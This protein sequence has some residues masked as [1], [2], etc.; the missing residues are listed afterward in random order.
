MGRYFNWTADQR[1]AR[2]CAT[3]HVS[4]LPPTLEAEGE[5]WSWQKEP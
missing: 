4:L 5:V 1:N 3:L 2:T